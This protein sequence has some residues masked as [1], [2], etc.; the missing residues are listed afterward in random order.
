M[1]KRQKLDGTAKGGIIFSIKKMLNI[2]VRFVGVGEKQE[3]LQPF[4]PDAF[5]DALF[6]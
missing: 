4:D 2:P 5:I 6:E 1:Y 3:D